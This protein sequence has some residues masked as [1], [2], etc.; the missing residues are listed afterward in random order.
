MGGGIVPT[1]AETHYRIVVHL[2]NDSVLRY[3]QA[4]RLGPIAI[5]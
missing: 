2:T 4:E 3:G 5:G 1:I